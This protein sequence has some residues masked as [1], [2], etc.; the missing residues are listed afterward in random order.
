MSRIQKPVTDSTA[1]DSEDLFRIVNLTSVSNRA[2]GAFERDQNESERTDHT[3][4]INGLVK[5]RNESGTPAKKLIELIDDE[6]LDEVALATSA[7][8]EIEFEE[9]DGPEI[10]EFGEEMFRLLL[11]SIVFGTLWLCM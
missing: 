7:K 10:S 9:E 2:S 8:D 5:L 3:G 6:E 4:Q 11:Y 1:V